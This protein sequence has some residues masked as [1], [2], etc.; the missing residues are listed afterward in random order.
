MNAISTL[1]VL[2]QSK[3]EISNYVGMIKSEILGG[4]INPLNSALMIK[5]F[6]EILK[7]LK[8]DEEIKA[9]VL[10]EADKYTEK[11]IDL[12]GAKITKQDRT[13]YY[14][15]NCNDSVWNDLN[16]QIEQLKCEIKGRESWLKTIRSITPDTQTGELINPPS[17][18]FNSILTITLRK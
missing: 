7:S 11:T 2:P 5:A 8:D 15:E 10:S 17:T 4:Y 14:Y 9:Y 18:K 1:T 16:A 6:E 3:E 12:N 13:T